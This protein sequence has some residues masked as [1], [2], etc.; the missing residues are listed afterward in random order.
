MSN[1]FQEVYTLNKFEKV[2]IERYND[3]INKHKQ[4]EDDVKQLE[5]A[6]HQNTQIVEDIKED[7]E[8]AAN[9]DEKEKTK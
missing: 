9:K 7:D 1:S 2:I 4:L 5:T 6:S 3:S 8:T